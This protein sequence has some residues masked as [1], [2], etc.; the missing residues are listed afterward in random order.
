MAS[1]KL[2]LPQL[3]AELRRQTIDTAVIHRMLIDAYNADTGFSV[4][5]DVAAASGEALAV[6]AVSPNS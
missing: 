5:Y 2:F 6:L 4:S 1:E 3:I